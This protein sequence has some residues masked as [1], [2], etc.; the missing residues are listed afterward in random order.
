MQA[1]EVQAIY[2]QV[3]A[4]KRGLP[5]APSSTGNVEE[6]TSQ[7]E[8]E[9]VAVDEPAPVV[10]GLGAKQATKESSPA[11]SGSS[12]ASQ[13]PA[14]SPRTKRRHKSKSTT[15]GKSRVTRSRVAKK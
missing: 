1:K 6:S 8:A 9:E 5:L 12:S 4:R 2:K 13:S 3:L 11:R 7:L 14:E 15:P 10:I